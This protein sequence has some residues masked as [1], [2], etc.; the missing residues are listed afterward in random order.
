V[1]L[2]ASDR[3]GIETSRM[4]R[5]SLRDAPPAVGA[6]RRRYRA[7]DGSGIETFRACCAY[8][9]EMRRLLLLLALPLAAC[10]TSSTPVNPLAAFSFRADRLPATGS[11]MHYVKSN[12]DGS[13]PA[14]VSLYVAGPDN[15]EVSK[16][17]TGVTDSADITGH[18]D[19]KRFTPDHLDSGVLNPD[20]TRE[21]RVTLDVK[22][23]EVIVKF[24]VFDQRLTVGVFPMHIYN[25]DLMGLNMTLPHLRNPRNGFT[26][27]FLEP[28]FQEGP[29]FVGVRG[30]VTAT[31]VRDET[32]HGVSVHRYSV[33]GP[34]LSGAGGTLWLNANDGFI[35][36]FA[37]PLPN[38]PDWSS[39]LLERHGAPEQMSPEQWQLFKRSHVG[40]GPESIL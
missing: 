1:R 6:T 8:R 28:T 2:S 9:C 3:S 17:E 30:R 23:D 19:W 29:E 4:L 31:F 7:G 12:L 16:S 13:K 18:I 5:V 21:S 24:G 35:E 37:S 26:V 36:R 11:V 15:I 32:L 33:N 40:L 27:A 34:G 10:A 39:Y 38:N 22:G 25:F 14:L 20:G